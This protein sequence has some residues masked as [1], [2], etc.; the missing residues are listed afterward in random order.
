MPVHLEKVMTL[1]IHTMEALVDTQHLILQREK[2]V[3]GHVSEDYSLDQ[4]TCQSYLLEQLNRC[5]S[6]IFSYSVTSWTER[7]PV[8]NSGGIYNERDSC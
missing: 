2:L 4:F 8:D 1:R 3:T 7:K 5:V 6:L